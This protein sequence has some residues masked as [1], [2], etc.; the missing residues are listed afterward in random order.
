MKQA[1]TRSDIKT[2]SLS[3]LGGALEFYDFIVFLTFIP[4]LKQHFFPEQ[5][6]LDSLM[7][8]Y[9]IYAVAYFVRPLSGMI[10]APFG[11]IVG[12][13]RMFMISL[14]LMA[15]PTLAIGL[16]PTFDDIGVWAPLL[17]LCMRLLQGIALGG[18]VPSAHVFVTEH[19]K[20][21][22]MGLANSLIAAGLTFGVFIGYAISTSLNFIFTEAEIH[23]YAWRFPF[24]IGG[25][26]GLLAL[27]LRRSLQETPVFLQFKEERKK[28]SEFP[29]K[30][31]L[32]KYLKESF[33][34]VMSTWLLMTG[35]IMVLLI[36]NLM[37]SELYGLPADFVNK[38][39]LLAT[40]MNIIGSVI[41]GLL[42]DRIGLPRTMIV[43]ATILG[44]S[45]TI[46]FNALGQGG[47]HTLIALLYMASSL[48]LGLV[49]CVPIFIV[50]LYEPR[51]RLSG[52]GFSYNIGNA[53]FGGLTT[54]LVP[55][56]AEQL[57]ENFVTHYLIFL[58][59]LGVALG[60]VAKRFR[61]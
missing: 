58:C 57:N 27:Y 50:R 13:K 15:V 16:L 17:L 61:L 23:A 51:V 5:S 33:W 30:T 2:L 46:F 40:A 32:Q 36:P 52:M 22:H 35:V 55:V 25:G 49:A 56:I 9:G 42:V 29:M 14:F 37:K 18:E 48:F 44:I 11:D 4:I 38:I 54:F 7:M 24:I 26:L 3:S 28:S 6:G 45:S 53:L 41:A 21:H 20:S 60:F 10:L 59:V 31:V 43:F 8:I 19:V 47:D 1:L 12:R 39:A 34:G